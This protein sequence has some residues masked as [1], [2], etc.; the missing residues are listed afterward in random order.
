MLCSA[1]ATQAPLHAPV[2]P[3]EREARRQALLALESWELHGRIAVRAGKDGW[4]AGFDWRQADKDYRI[5]LRG[6]FGQGA[7]KLE[8]DPRGVWLTRAGQPAV[9]STDPEALLE[10]ESGWRLPIIGLAR[11]LRGLPGKQGSAVSQ[12][13]TAGRLVSLQQRG[14]QIDYSDYQSYGDYV[15]PT[16]L[17]LQ[18]QDLRVKVLIDRWELP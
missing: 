15:L 2:D 5:Q 10:Q 6:P 8:G 9:F 7:L 3:G 11:W 1:C 17:V 12:R 16:R 13:D 14:W 4:S 18:R